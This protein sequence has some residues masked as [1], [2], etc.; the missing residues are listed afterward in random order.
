MLLASGRTRVQIDV[1]QVLLGLL[2]G[3][4]KSDFPNEKS[5]LQWKNRQVWS[6]LEYFKNQSF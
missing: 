2:N 5:Y 4:F 6:T 1:P 3:T